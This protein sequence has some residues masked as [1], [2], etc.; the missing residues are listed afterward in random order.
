MKS[1]EFPE[2]AGDSGETPGCLVASENELVPRSWVE[3]LEVDEEE[4]LRG[5][6]AMSLEEY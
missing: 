6:I 4:M 2:F 3:N 5:A 1:L